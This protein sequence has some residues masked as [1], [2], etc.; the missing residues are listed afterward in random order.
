LEDH[1]VETELDRPVI[2]ETTTKSAPGKV[3]VY[4]KPE[5]RGL[6]R[7][8]WIGLLILALI[9]AYFLWQLAL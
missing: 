8:V 2:P 5:R 4:D 9:I 1:K 6:S 3:G 7:A